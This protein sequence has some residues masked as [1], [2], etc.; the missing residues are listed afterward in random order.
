MCL[1][2][3]LTLRHCSE[4]QVLFFMLIP[5]KMRNFFKKNLSILIFKAGFISTAA[6]TNNNS[7][8]VSVL[9]FLVISS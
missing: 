2:E 4:N 1:L 7:L 6:M 8:C 3:L 5:F 9:D